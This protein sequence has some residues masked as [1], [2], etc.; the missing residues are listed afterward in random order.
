MGDGSRRP[1][2]VYEDID[3][4]ETLFDR[5]PPAQAAFRGG[6]RSV[7]CFYGRSLERR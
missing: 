7:F 3:A 6:G 1:S 4:I 2:R 5:N